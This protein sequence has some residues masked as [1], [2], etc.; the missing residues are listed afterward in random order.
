MRALT[1]IV[2]LLILATA[3]LMA[4]VWEFQLKEPL[5]GREPEP[6]VHKVENVGVSATLVAV[7][8]I[9]PLWLLGGADQDR[10]ELIDSLRSA[11]KVFEHSTDG[12]MLADTAGKVLAVNPAFTQVTGF[13]GKDALGRNMWDL[14]SD[15]SESEF[16]E[17]M[18]SSVK[19]KGDWTGAVVIHARG[20]EPIPVTYT[21]S[22][23]RNE[24][25]DAAGYVAMLARQAGNQQHDETGSVYARGETE[26]GPGSATT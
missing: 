5:L 15:E 20:G 11:A 24:Q 25:G 22:V 10:Q 17:L 12:V 13:R 8:L 3:G 6:I 21:M 9:V 1:V 2:F 16:T 4:T 7:S 26:S 19:G 23:V 14:L 18:W